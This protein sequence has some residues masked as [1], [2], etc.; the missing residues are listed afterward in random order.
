MVLGLWM[1]LQKT[2]KKAPAFMFA[3]L[4]DAK[5]FRFGSLTNDE[6]SYEFTDAKGLRFARLTNAK[7]LWEFTNGEAPYGVEMNC[8]ILR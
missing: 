7:G 6:A 4:T 3:R 5:G 1:F 2:G 8:L